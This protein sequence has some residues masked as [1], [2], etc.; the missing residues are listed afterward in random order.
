MTLVQGR[1]KRCM[2]DLRA[3]HP[4]EGMLTTAVLRAFNFEKTAAYDREGQRELI[5]GLGK[6]LADH[7]SAGLCAWS[8]WLRLFVND[9]CLSEKQ[10]AKFI[11]QAEDI[12]PPRL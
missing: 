7:G 2:K 5:Y 3:A 6:Q 8:T 12:R 4:A 10:A 9:G 1:L 11:Q